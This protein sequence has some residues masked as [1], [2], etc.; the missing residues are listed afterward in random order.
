V[1]SPRGGGGS[2]GLAG[3]AVVSAAAARVA[4]L[5]A[6]F[7]QRA[8][9]NPRPSVSAAED[10]LNA[11]F[12]QAVSA[13]RKQRGAGSANAA[14]PWISAVRPLSRADRRELEAALQSKVEFLCYTARAKE[15]NDNRAR[16]L[17]DWAL[18]CRL[19]GHDAM[20]YDKAGVRTLHLFL[21]WR[22][23]SWESWR[24]KKGAA[25]RRG[26][27]Y[28]SIA[29]AL[30]SIRTWHFEHLGVKLAPMD[31]LSRLIQRA[32]KRVEG[33]KKGAFAVD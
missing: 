7:V 21:A 20:L 4:A 33:P 30:S 8:V 3:P 23:L 11:R 27:S 28:Q 15:T 22:A 26:L 29:N 17:R 18:F 31:Q 6:E 14:G 24:K 2:A 12:K 32:V 16:D 9:D 25:D 13:Q 1:V 5:E 19:L 10:L